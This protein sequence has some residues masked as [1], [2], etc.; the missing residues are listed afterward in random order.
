MSRRH[1]NIIIA[2]AISSLVAIILYTSGEVEYWK[3]PTISLLVFA[4]FYGHLN[5]TSKWKN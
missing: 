3:V 5:I 4:V 2:A 1:I